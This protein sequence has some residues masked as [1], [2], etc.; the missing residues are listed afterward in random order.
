MRT[1]IGKYSRAYATLSDLALFATIIIKVFC[2]RLFGN[3]GSR[4]QAT[5]RHHSRR[6]IRSVLKRYHGLA[7]IGN[8]IPSEAPCLVLGMLCGGYSRMSTKVYL[9]RSLLQDVIPALE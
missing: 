8:S 1:G 9:Q 7:A 2:E 3:N 4:L 5:S 6:A